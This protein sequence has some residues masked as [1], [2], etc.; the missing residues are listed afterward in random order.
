M[1]CDFTSFSTI[2]QSYQ[3]HGR[4]I[5]K[6]CVKG[7]P[8]YGWEDFTSSTT[9]WKNLE[10][11][12]SYPCCLFLCGATILYCNTVKESAALMDRIPGRF[13]DMNTINCK[14]TILAEQLIDNQLFY[15]TDLGILVQNSDET[16]E[17]SPPNLISSQ[18]Y[19]TSTTKFD[20]FT[21]FINL[22]EKYTLTNNICICI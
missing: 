1:A 14:W 4:L 8:I 5:M 18:K 22:H 6:G 13:D 11:I 2:F 17:P 3:D 9:L 15:K 20:L 10:N 16:T 21:E 12:L 19:R 7:N